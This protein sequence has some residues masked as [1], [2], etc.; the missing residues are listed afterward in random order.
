M[1]LS[2]I[3]ERILTSVLFKGRPVPLKQALCTDLSEVGERLGEVESLRL[4]Q[5][6][7]QSQGEMLAWSHQ[8][9]QSLKILSHRFSWLMLLQV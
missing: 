9:A 3:D 1:L 4:Y 2:E 7:Q 6:D 8:I 5:G